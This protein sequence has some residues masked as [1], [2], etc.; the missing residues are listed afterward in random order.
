MRRR[1][2]YGHF[3]EKFPG[4]SG[5]INRFLRWKRSDGDECFIYEC[6]QRFTCSR[7]FTATSCDAILNYGERRERT[8]LLQKTPS[9]IKIFHGII[10][11][12]KG[13]QVVAKSDVNHF[14]WMSNL[15]SI[16]SALESFRFFP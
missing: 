2:V 14:F 7:L 4:I 13:T 9:S 8:L 11:Q 10:C 15:K 3:N 1:L 12:T 6:S 5:T 16:L